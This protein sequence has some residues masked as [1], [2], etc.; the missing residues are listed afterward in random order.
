MLQVMAEQLNDRQLRELYKQEDA[1]HWL[2]CSAKYF[3]EFI[4]NWIGEPITANVDYRWLTNKAVYIYTI[5]SFKL[6]AMI[7]VDGYHKVKQ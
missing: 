7:D 2:P 5:E 4:H 1:I 6:I 3:E